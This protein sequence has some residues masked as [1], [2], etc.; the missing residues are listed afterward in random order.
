VSFKPKIYLY[1]KI[2]INKMSIEQDTSANP[3]THPAL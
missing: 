3:I 2:R 1:N